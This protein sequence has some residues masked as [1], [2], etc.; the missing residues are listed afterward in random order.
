MIEKAS[1][2]KSE[3]NDYHRRRN[4]I[5]LK[6]VEEMSKEPYTL[7]QMREQAMMVKHSSPDEKDKDK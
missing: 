3:L 5:A 4:K 6:N 1:Q 2:E 7:E